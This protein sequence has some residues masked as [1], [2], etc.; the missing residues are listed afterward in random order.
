MTIW[1]SGKLNFL[2]EKIIP[3]QTQIWSKSGFW[4][5]ELIQKEVNFKFIAVKLVNSYKSNE[6]WIASI[7]TIWVREGEANDPRVKIY[8]LISSNKQMDMLYIDHISMWNP[9]LR[10]SQHTSMTLPYGPPNTPYTESSV[11]IWLS[12][13]Q[14]E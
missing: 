2:G 6:W 14:K 1:Q 3:I 13:H 11:I 4:T 7:N 10:P 5:E 12:N 9:A 8:N